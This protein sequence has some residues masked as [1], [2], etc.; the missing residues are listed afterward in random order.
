MNGEAPAN[1][2]PLDS[3]VVVVVGISEKTQ[4]FGKAHGSA[5]VVVGVL[6]AYI[7]HSSVFRPIHGP[8]N[9]RAQ[10]LFRFGL[11]HAVA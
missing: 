2:A 3:D 1:V 8:Q 6:D 9:H 7:I 5:V 11:C 4:A 10:S